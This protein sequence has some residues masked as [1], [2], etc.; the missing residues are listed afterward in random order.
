[1]RKAISAGRFRS[2]NSPQHS[3]ARG[4]YWLQALDAVAFRLRLGQNVG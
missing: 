2:Y 4:V 3:A 1:M